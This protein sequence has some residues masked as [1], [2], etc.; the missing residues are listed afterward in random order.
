MKISLSFS[1]SGRKNLLL[2]NFRESSGF[3]SSNYAADLD[4]LMTTCIAG[5]FP[6]RVHVTVVQ[7]SKPTP[8]S[9]RSAPFGNHRVTSL[10]ETIPSCKTIYKTAIFNPS[11]FF[12]CFSFFIQTYIHT[13]QPITRFMFA[14]CLLLQI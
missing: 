6:K 13:M 7:K 14:T 9:F 3:R 8:I 11:C 10:K 1:H 5:A 12:S 4:D 2:A